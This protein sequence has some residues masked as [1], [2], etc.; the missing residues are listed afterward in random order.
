MC[1]RGVVVP[2]AG[3]A[4]T[5][6]AMVI[7]CIESKDITCP[8]RCSCVHVEGRLTTDCS[9]SGYDQLPNTIA[10]GTMVLRLDGN[11]LSQLTKLQ[12]LPGR[13]IADLRQLSL[14]N[15]RLTAFPPEA[16]WDLPHLLRLNL[17]NNAISSI[18]MHTKTH[19]LW[20]PF[21]YMADLQYKDSQTYNSNVAVATAVGNFDFTE[22]IVTEE[23]D[24][25]LKV[26]QG[27]AL[28][29]VNLENRL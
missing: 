13:K 6:F 25:D 8:P 24:E 22:Y 16:F 26:I 12:F 9:N 17:A 2:A 3:T 27:I 10:E 21:H 29:S 14:K 19:Q 5:L 1:R 11:D 20:S 28:S 7:S 4:L 18:P 15:C 23:D